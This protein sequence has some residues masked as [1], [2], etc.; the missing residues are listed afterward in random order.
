M[1]NL[2]KEGRNPEDGVIQDKEEEEE[3]DIYHDI[4]EGSARTKKGERD[5][6]GENKSSRAGMERG[7]NRAVTQ[8]SLNSKAGGWEKRRNSTRASCTGDVT[9]KNDGHKVILLGRGGTQRSQAEAV[10]KRRTVKQTRGE[11]GHCTRYRWYMWGTKATVYN[12]IS[13]VQGAVFIMIS[14][15]IWSLVQATPMMTSKEP[16]HSKRREL[17]NCLQGVCLQGRD[18]ELDLGEKHTPYILC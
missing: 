2:Q 6:K 4:I 15:C 14:T 17:R 5:I 9:D 8:E 11:S 10:K 3:E 1:G 13:K 18:E 12:W 7:R 16:L